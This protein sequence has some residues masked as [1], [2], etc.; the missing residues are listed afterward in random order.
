MEKL[1]AGLASR[2]IPLD[3]AAD[4]IARFADTQPPDQRD[5]ALKQLFAGLLDTDQS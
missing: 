4:A 2:R 3:Q 5:D 1:I